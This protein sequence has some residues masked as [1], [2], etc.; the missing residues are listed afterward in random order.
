MAPPT[1]SAQSVR[2]LIDEAERALAAGN[3]RAA[4]DK[5]E[6]CVTM[7][8]PGNREC[9]AFKVHADRM[10]REQRRCALEG[11]QWSEDRCR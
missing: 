4:S 11:R 3:Y 1:E 2:N 6:V 5:L 8:D 7:V 10:Q 9:T